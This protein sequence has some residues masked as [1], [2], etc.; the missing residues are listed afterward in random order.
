MIAVEGYIIIEVVVQADNVLCKIIQTDFQESVAVGIVKRQN[1]FVGH[2][3]ITIAIGSCNI[4]M[5]SVF[6]NFEH[7]VTVRIQGCAE[8]AFEAGNEINRGNSVDTDAEV[9]LNAKS[10]VYCQLVHSDEGDAIFGN[11]ESARQI[12]A[13]IRWRR[14]DHNG[15]TKIKVRNRQTKRIFA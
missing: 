3:S 13:Q 6:G 15:N 5:Q 9:Q 2:N 14:C 7:A 1:F 8:F 10:A 4:R 12:D 11:I